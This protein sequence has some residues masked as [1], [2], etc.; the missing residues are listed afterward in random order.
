M[1]RRKSGGEYRKEKIIVTASS[2]LVLT[3]LTVT[4]VYLYNSSRPVEPRD[5]VVD[6]SALEGNTEAQNEPVAQAENSS[7]RNVTSGQAD[8]GELD[9]DPYYAEQDRILNGQSAQ[10]QTP[11]QPLSDEPTVL[12]PEEEGLSVGYAEISGSD[13][14]RAEDPSGQEEST[15]ESGGQEEAVLDGD[16]AQDE[17]AEG[18]AADAAS[19]AEPAV[20]AVADVKREEANLHFSEADRLEWPIVGNVLLNYSMD[21][22]IFFQTLQ[23]YKYNPSI[24]IGAVQG[25]SV[26]CAAEGV[27]KS[28]YQD[29][30]TGMTVVMNLGD[31]YELTYGQLQEITVEEGD[32]VETGVF[33]GKVAAPTKYYTVEGTNVY[34]KLTKDGE[35]V[36]PLNYLG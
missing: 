30:Q 10:D 17:P 11:D 25:T 33:L 15:E 23:Q 4:G 28:V 21:K 31:G 8:S 5:N 36:N 1:K 7:A 9:Y 27:V 32:F 26:A 29:P 19:Q 12:M 20:E 34:F 3:A 35:P 24:V 13:A 6:F 16:E 18:A 2:V 14:A 22:T